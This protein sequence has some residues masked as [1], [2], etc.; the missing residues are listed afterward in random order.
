MF[1]CNEITLL[2]F[3]RIWFSRDDDDDDNDNDDDDDDDDDDGHNADVLNMLS[4]LFV[5][6]R[7]KTKK[8]T[9]PSL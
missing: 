9:L 1:C 7:R 3:L 2:L 4:I 8:I 6:R 5:K